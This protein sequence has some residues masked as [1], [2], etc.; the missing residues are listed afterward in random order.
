MKSFLKS[1]KVS[2]IDR[3]FRLSRI[4]SNSEIKKISGLFS[5]RVI[6]VSAGENIDKE[7]SHYDQYFINASEF[8]ISNFSPGSFR[9]F[10]GGE[11]EL[12]IDLTS[13]LPQEYN[14]QFDVVFN[15][16]T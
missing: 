16:Q 14:G 10:R 3:K 6:N 4:W 1:F 12:L 11:K 9:G 13:D 15:H 5:G 8:W 2:K 7:G